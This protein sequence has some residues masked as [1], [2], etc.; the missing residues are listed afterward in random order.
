M[1][2]T[3][4]KIRGS[5]FTRPA[6]RFNI[7]TRTEKVNC[8]ALCFKENYVMTKLYYQSNVNNFYF[9]FSS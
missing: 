5:F 1:G 7:D 9:S 3:V 2:K 4:S 8:S 6:Q